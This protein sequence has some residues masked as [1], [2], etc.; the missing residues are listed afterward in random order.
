M[1]GHGNHELTAA[2]Y[3][4]IEVGPPNSGGRARDAGP[5][6]LLLMYQANNRAWNGEAE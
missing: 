5:Y 4:G 6:Y 2:V 3:T 1:H